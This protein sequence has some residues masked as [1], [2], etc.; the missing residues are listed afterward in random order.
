MSE[1]TKISWCDSTHN[2]WFGCD[3][4][5]EGCVNCYARRV[6]ARLG[7]KPGERKRASEATRK[8]PLKWNKRLMCN[9]GT[10]QIDTEDSQTS[11]CPV[12]ESAY[13]KRRVFCGSLMDWLDP[14][15]PMAWFTDLL[16]TIVRTSNIDWLLLTKRPELYTFSMRE[17]RD[18]GLREC[19]N[20]SVN[21]FGGALAAWLCQGNR[22][23]NMW[24]GVTAENQEQWDNRV[25]TL[26]QIPAAKRF[27]SVEPMISEIN[28]GL[29]GVCPELWNKGYSPIS[30]HIDWVIFGGESGPNA[31][32]CNI[33]WIRDGVRQ[34]KEAG[35]PAFVKQMG[36]KPF[37]QVGDSRFWQGYYDKKGGEPAE[38]PEDLRV[39][40]FPE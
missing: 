22:Q 29:T 36:A 38:W 7:V 16:E 17:A 19:G 25:P 35:V 40:E 32:P 8:E 23:S 20:G 18:Y 37:N 33:Q 34:C 27:V 39:R 5:S 12:C 31:R 21:A 14:E 2:P 11:E 1:Q 9:C 24:I 4:V 13:R 3:P 15:V 10:V 26:L 28:M 30:E 6:W